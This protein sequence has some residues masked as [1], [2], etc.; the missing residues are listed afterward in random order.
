MLARLQRLTTL[1]LLLAAA[2]WALWASAHGHPGW[3]TGGTAVI[4]FGYALV[5]GIE[6]ILMHA[7]NRN[8]TAPR[9][10]LRQVLGAWAGEVLTAPL[11]FCWRQP[12][13]SQA[14]PDPPAIDA[15][16][17]AGAQSVGVIFVHGFLCNRGVW[18]PWLKRL[19]E[20][21]TPFAAVN[22][23]PVFGSIDHYASTIDAAVRR[24]SEITGH[25]P[26]IVAHSMGGLAVRFW[27][28]RFD[29]DAR[30]SHIITIGSPHHGTWLGRFGYSIN[31]RQMRQRS[32]WL[33]ALA[34]SELP[35][36][37]AKFT[38]FYG[39]CDNI[40]FPASNGCLSGARNIHLS[41]CAHVQMAHHEE[42]F[43]ELLR[44]LGMGG[45]SSAKRGNE[46]G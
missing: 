25:P 23:E 38:C 24:L 12:F 14:I 27:L 35:H 8:D 39:H 46:E 1:S 9:A 21:G 30:V 34:T 3:A 4:L 45:A 42:V 36:R 32:A 2:S 10:T 43:Q 11:V 22:L 5:L 44:R 37:S 29:A 7:I 15:T 26:L 33:T 31:T 41:G 28:K 17:A 13:R 20:I 40:V 19:R 16:R 6:F 18:N